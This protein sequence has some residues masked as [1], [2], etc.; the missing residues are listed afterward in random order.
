L[1][2]AA[3]SAGHEV[4]DRRRAA[5]D[6]TQAARPGPVFGEQGRVGFEVSR[7]EGTTIVDQHV[8]NLLDILQTLDLDAQRFDRGGRLPLLLRP[9]GDEGQRDTRH[10]HESDDRAG[11]MTALERELLLHSPRLL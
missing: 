6:G 11:Q 2:A 8:R 7:I 4:I 3:D 5:R 9:Y 10:E 1:P